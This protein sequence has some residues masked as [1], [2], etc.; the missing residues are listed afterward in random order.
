VLGT[1]NVFS[2]ALY[3][4]SPYFLEIRVVL[5]HTI[6]HMGVEVFCHLFLISALYMLAAV[7]QEKEPLVCTG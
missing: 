5:V 2:L 4:Y 3:M 6:T 7:P 1:I